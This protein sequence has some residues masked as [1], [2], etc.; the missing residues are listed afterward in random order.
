MDTEIAVRDLADRQRLN[1]LPVIAKE[2]GLDTTS[3]ASLW[4]DRAVLEV[5]TAVLYSF[6][7]ANVT[8]VDHYTAS[9]SF[10]THLKNENRLRGGCPADWVSV[11]YFHYPFFSLL[12]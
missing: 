2:M 10:M 8:I 1:I 11:K 6:Q 9:E 7:Q 3:N 5:N 12:L 4:K